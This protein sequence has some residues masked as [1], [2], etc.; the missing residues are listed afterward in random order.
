MVPLLLTHEIIKVQDIGT[1]SVNSHKSKHFDD[2]GMKI[3][4]VKHQKYVASTPEEK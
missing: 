2:E 3:A 1:S 4:I